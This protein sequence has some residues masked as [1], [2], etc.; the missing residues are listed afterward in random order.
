MLD[1][2]EIRVVTTP[3]YHS[4][5]LAEHLERVD[6]M[7]QPQTWDLPK[8]ESNLDQLLHELQLLATRVEQPDLCQQHDASQMGQGQYYVATGRS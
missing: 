5:N 2:S 1:G 4:H 6:R 3:I 7:E 8:L